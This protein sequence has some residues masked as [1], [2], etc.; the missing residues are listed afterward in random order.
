MFS[1]AAETPRGHVDE[2]H[3]GL[4]LATSAGTGVLSVVGRN[5][6]CP[7]QVGDDGVMV[8]TVNA[9]AALQGLGTRGVLSDRQRPAHALK[10]E[11]VR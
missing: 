1:R 5:G 2:Q 11:A 6:G 9:A 7:H 3:R 4:E 8:R 10:W